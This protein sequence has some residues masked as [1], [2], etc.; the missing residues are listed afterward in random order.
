MNAKEDKNMDRDFKDIIEI[1]KYQNQMITFL[2]KMVFNLAYQPH[3]Y[4]Q[5]LAN[6]SREADEYVKSK[7]WNK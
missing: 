4:N 3:N 5:E 1:I 2:I 6:I 7:S